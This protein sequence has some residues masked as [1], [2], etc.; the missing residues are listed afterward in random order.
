V[1][2][3]RKDIEAEIK[4]HLG[5]SSIF[6]LPAGIEGDDTDGHIDDITRFIREDV[7]LTVLEKRETD[8]NYRV[9]RENRERLEDLRT[10]DGGKVEILS[11]GMPAPLTPSGGWRLDRLPA[12]YANFLI[13]NGAVLVPVF[14]QGKRDQHALGLIGECFPERKVIGIESSDIVFEGGALHCISQQQPRAGK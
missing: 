2:W 6:W 7:V 13:I 8:A 9:L 4:K 11:M 3:S 10:A 14:N 12:S 5:V 1:E